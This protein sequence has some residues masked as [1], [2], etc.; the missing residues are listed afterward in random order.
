VPRPLKFGLYIANSG[1]LA[2]P[3]LIRDLAEEAERRGY[4]GVWCNEHPIPAHEPDYEWPPGRPWKLVK[5]SYVP[6]YGVQTTLAYVAGRTTKVR[7]GCSVHPMP[8]YNAVMLAKMI[9]TLDQLSGG[10]AILGTAVGWNRQ[11]MEAIGFKDF[12]ARGAY[13]DESIECIR[14]LWTE[15]TPSFHGRWYNFDEVDFEPKPVQKPHP[16]IWI[17]G[18]SK[19]TI[20]R[21]AKYGTGWLLSH[22]SPDF[23]RE[24]VPLLRKRL[25]ENGRADDEIEIGC[26]YNVK[27]LKNGKRVDAVEDTRV[28]GSGTWLSGPAEAYLKDLAVYAECGITYP[29]LRIHGD[30][31][32]DVLKQLQMFDE[33]VRARLVPSPAG[34]GG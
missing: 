27:M 4:D 28:S 6:S 22:M 24:H 7:L 8:Y 10:R 20:R 25:A 34:R 17:G 1:P 33:E 31:H 16:P 11:E 19:P 5:W 23:L 14:A 18:E 15:K 12:E 13:T 2:T 26:F 32:D 9:A 21:V 30:D 29:I 3:E